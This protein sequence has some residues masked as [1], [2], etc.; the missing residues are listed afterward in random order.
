MA[1]PLQDEQ[2][3]LKITQQLDRLR[4]QAEAGVEMPAC[5]R[6][7]EFYGICGHF[8]YSQ[9]CNDPCKIYADDELQDPATCCDESCAV[10]DNAPI[11][12][13]DMLCLW[14]RAFPDQ[15]ETT[16]TRSDGGLPGLARLSRDEIERRRTEQQQLR[17]ARLHDPERRAQ[18]IRHHTQ[19]VRSAEQAALQ[20]ID[21]LWRKSLRDR[22]FFMGQGYDDTPLFAPITSSASIMGDR[23]CTICQEN[24][25]LQLASEQPG[26]VQLPCSHAFHRDCIEPW[27]RDNPTCPVC[28]QFY[29]IHKINGDRDDE[30]V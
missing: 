19:S 25:D 16:S 22:I 9:R 8:V 20:R 5:E 4:E 18:A 13:P 26:G 30:G 10:N 6:S 29:H 7:T 15:P 2:L 21:E 11:L 27:I 28:R 23:C 17:R 3:R 1:Q 12:L 14:C 24:G